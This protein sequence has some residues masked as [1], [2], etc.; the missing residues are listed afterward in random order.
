[1]IG[2]LGNDTLNGGKGNDTID[3]GAGNDTLI[4]EKGNDSFQFATALNPAT[5]V[6][7]ITGF[8]VADDTILLE[9]AVFTALPSGGTLPSSNFAVGAAAAQV[10]DFIIYNNLTGGLFYDS[11]GN[12][13][14]AAQVQFA[15]LDPGLAITNN[16]FI[17]V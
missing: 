12:G 15:T 10:D 17:L 9:N 14:A 7:Q 8:S 2:G 3:G 1:L 5:N 11:D 4:G 16:D 6:D 13:A